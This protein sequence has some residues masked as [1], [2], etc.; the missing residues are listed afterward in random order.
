MGS[1]ATIA[2]IAAIVAIE[3]LLHARVIMLRILKAL[4]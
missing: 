4:A 1:P 2:T 3:A